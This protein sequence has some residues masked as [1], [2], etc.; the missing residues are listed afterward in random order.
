MPSIAWDVNFMREEARRLP[1]S[2]RLELIEAL[3]HQLKDAS[4]AVSE[5]LLDIRTLQG[6]GKEHWRGIDPQVYIDEDRSA[7]E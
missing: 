5:P 7:W 1:P 3:V 6:L 4:L 2:A